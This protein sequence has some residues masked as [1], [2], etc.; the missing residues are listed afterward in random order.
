MH[1]RVAQPGSPI[2]FAL[3]LGFVASST[4]CS[5]D[6]TRPG[7]DEAVTSLG[8]SESA[9]TTGNTEDEIG[10]EDASTSDS[11]TGPEC[12]DEQIECGAA[13]C[14]AGQVCFEGACDDDCGGVPA[15]G[16][17]CCS[18]AEVCYLGSCVLPAG[19]CE[20]S[21]CATKENTSTCDPGYVCDADLGQCVPSMADPNCQY[22][23]PPAEFA[24]RPEFT[25]GTR[26]QVA[27]VDDS[28]C[29][30]AEVCVNSVCTPSW[31]HV[32]VIDSPAQT[33]V[34]SIPIVGD[35]DGDC[36]P[37]IVFNSYPSGEP[38]ANGILRALRGDTGEQVWW[39]SDP[40]YQS[41]G[42]ANPAL[43]N[44][45]GDPQ[46]EVVVQ[47]EGKYLIAIDHDGTPLWTSQPFLG[48]ETS[49]SVAIANLDGQGDPEIVFGAAVYSS[50]GTKLWEGNAGIGFDLQ[51]PISCIA[52][53]DGDLRPELI[54]GRTAYKTT[55]T[56]AGGDFTGMVY[57][58]A[59]PGDGKCGV[60]DFDADGLAEVI[61]VRGGSIFALD[62][63]NG[64]TITS[65]PIPGTADG[66]GAPNIADFD[67][68]G[69]PDVATAGASRYVVV[70]FDGTTFTELWRAV[71]EDD[72]SRVTGSSVFDFD[73]DG[74]NEVIY[75]DEKFLRIY[76]GIE[77]DCALDPPGPLCDGVMDDSEVLFRDP[78]TSRT[79]TEYPVVAD[80]D[81]D[82]KA[83]LVFSSNSDIA[84]GLDAGIEVWGDSLDNWVSTRP[85][86]N[87]H[88]YH[89]T[90]VGI[91][92]GIPLVEP[93]SWL[94]P[95]GD[96]YN[97]YRCNVQGA[98]DF[99]APNL[100][101]FDLRADEMSCPT[102]NLSVD[103]VNIGCLGVGPGVNVS[104]FSQDLGFLGTVQ[105][106]NALPAGAK[107]TVTLE[108]MVQESNAMIWAVV[109]EDEQ[110][111]GLLNECD[112]DN[113]SPT[114]EVCI[115][116][117]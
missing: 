103:V 117:G 116:I 99:C 68:D 1:F 43:G 22:I 79:R 53:L 25:W 49:G 44:I 91:D 107:E 26:E 80:V 85:I 45:D 38:G 60:A 18:D 15:C 77:P 36:V 27:C 114:I 29:Q 97:N 35:L 65:M 62:G 11:E 92:G 75:N 112:E 9:D 24:P 8:T 94:T 108:T 31:P 111:Q 50:T 88:S 72:S 28:V 46:L 106:Q 6:E 81:G 20:E 63:Q 87:Q 52:D 3:A 78:S 33:H 17:V 66:G 84:W 57:W 58:T 83:E 19:P 5:D 32:P 70:S 4:A 100:E 40:A 86:W 41:D 42:T 30:T 105:T 96:P 98:S 56:V 39:V 109:D 34:S 64:A 71:T 69:Q 2:P 48:A 16:D 54:G 73:G 61:L 7:D 13:C 74:R 47:G 115:P 93:S 104:F 14:E 10:S 102:L 82:F 59:M 51:G 95:Q 76:P 67:G 113:Q 21:G 101:L 89:I 37:E 55:G 12:T 110:G 23:P 90:N